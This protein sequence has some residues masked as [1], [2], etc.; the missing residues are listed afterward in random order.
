MGKINENLITIGTSSTL[1]INELSKRLENK[2][3]E[4]FKFGLGQSPF[5]IPNVVVEELKKNSYKKDYLDVSG[6][7]ELR[8]SVA[9]YFSKLTVIL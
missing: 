4:V 8:E 2:G 7:F 9:K 6:L 3:N 5:P 1:A